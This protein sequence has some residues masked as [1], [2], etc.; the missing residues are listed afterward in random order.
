MHRLA[1]FFLLAFPFAAQAD[2]FKCTDNAGKVTYSNSACAK[3]GLKEAKLI[4]PPP[5]PALDKSPPPKTAES[6]RPVAEKNADRAKNEQVVALTM[7]RP[8]P[9]NTEKCAKL[10]GDVGRLLDQLD[11]TRRSGEVSSQTAEWDKTLKDLQSEKNRLG[12]F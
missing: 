2:L 6:D 1:I 9:G 3:S 11:A 12:C 10:N 4:P 8:A 5:P 7:V